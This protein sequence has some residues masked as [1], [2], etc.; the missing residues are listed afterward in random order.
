MT[1]GWLGVAIQNVTPP[2]TESLGL[3]L[4]HPTDAP[5]ASVTTD[6]PAVRT[7]I[8]QGD[9]IAAAGGHEIKAVYD[10]PG[11]VASTPVGTKLELT[12]ARDGKQKTVE[13]SIGEMPQSVAS[14]EREAAQ[15][16]S[17]KP[18]NMLGM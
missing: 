7:G 2:I 14:A 9:V 17:G 11:L 10:L 18:A 12:I 8:K 13:A 15:P 5:V 16:G 1:W 4:D 6:S 3:D